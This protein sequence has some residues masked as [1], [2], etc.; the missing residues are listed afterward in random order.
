MK[1]IF[2][3]LALIIVVFSG[4]KKDLSSDETFSLSYGTSF[5][6]CVGYCNKTLKVEQSMLLF[7]QISND[8]ILPPKVC[9][10]VLTEQEKRELYSLIKVNNI[11]SLSETTECPDCADGGAEMDIHN[12]EWQNL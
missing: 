9:K 7:T 11:K 5:G 6:F 10:A 1:R 3:L 12:Y 4:C 2:T 8:K